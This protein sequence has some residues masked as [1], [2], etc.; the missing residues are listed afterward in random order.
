[1]R[2]RKYWGVDSEYL[3]AG[4]RIEDDVINIGFSDGYN[5]NRA[6]RN[7][8][9]AKQFL[10]HKRLTR[11]YTWTLRPEFGTF[12]CWRLLGVED[13]TKAVDIESETIQR[14]TVVRASGHKTLV[15]DIQPFFKPLGLGSLAQAAKFLL[16][17]QNDPSLYKVEMP[18]SWFG[19][20]RPKTDNEWRLMDERVKQDARVTSRLAEFLEQTLLPR[21][22]LKPNLKKLYSWGTVSRRAF[23]F[24]QINPR[25]GRSII[26]KNW[27]LTIHELAEFAGRNEAFSTG[28]LPPTHYLDVPSLYPISVIA[29]DCLRIVD[30]EPM[31]Q[32]ELDA[33]SKPSDCYPYGWLC[34]SFDSMDDLWGLP[35]RSLKRNYYVTGRLFGLYHSLDLQASKAKIHELAFGFKPVFAPSRVMH[36]IYANLTLQKLEGRYVDLLEKYGIKQIVNDA[37]GSLGMS[38]PQPSSTSNFPAY[39]TG[40]AMSHLIMSR[41][42]DLAPKPI[43]YIDTDSLFVEKKLE[44]E[45]FTLTDLEGK[46][47]VP[48]VLEERTFAEQP[49]VFRSKLYYLNPDN[50]AVQ[51]VHIE[52]SDW[53]KIV[54]NLP[55]KTTA[56]RQI[57]GTIRT[58]SKKAKELQFG[59]WFYEQQ[60]LAA[61]DLATMFKAD[62]KRCRETYDS[63]ALCREK[64]FVGSRAWTAKEFYQQKLKD[65][66]LAIEL[67]SGKKHTR[68]FVREWLEKYSKSR[69]EV[70]KFCLD[71]RL[72]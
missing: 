23:R 9:D 41:L 38:K 57:R 45:M 12:A 54:T 72:K 48:V 68:S 53:L 20:R 3:S 16:E 64:R 14:F 33:I 35:A 66:D 7:A 24:P 13:P 5:D 30:V 11:L 29:S 63:Y 27:H 1:M 61:T 44:G 51:A 19:N 36:D 21:F 34:G 58:K 52:F 17:Y 28:C 65:D 71:Y 25:Q 67:P 60:E 43:H 42:F 49:Y 70:P 6:Y 47:T 37:L 22:I 18:E 31:T 26:V 8:A 40:L 46:I 56:Q 55:D 32:T 50:Y 2:K 15:L 4:K 10:E 69:Q 62:D 39:S 59:R